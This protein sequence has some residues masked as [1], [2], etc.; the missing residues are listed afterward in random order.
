MECGKKKGCRQS[1]CDVQTGMLSFLG[2]PFNRSSE[3][4]SS[5]GLEIAPSPATDFV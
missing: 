2:I 5:P 3:S 4:F 1:G